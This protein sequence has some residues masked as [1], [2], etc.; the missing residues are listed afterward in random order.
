MDDADA[1]DGAVPGVVPDAASKR[2]RLLYS[3][4]V[5]GEVFAVRSHNDGTDYDWVSGP[6]KDYGF[7]T[8]G[9]QNMSED[10]HRESIRNFLSMI[11]PATGY[12]ADD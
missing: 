1:R 7:G 12:I 6:N 9:G 4:D 3:L 10:W 5:D 2:G 8:S 11:D